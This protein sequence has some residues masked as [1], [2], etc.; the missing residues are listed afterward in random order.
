MITYLPY[1]NPEV[2]AA[3]LLDSELHLQ[4]VHTL[5]L[6][7]CLHETD[8]AAVRGWS[9]HPIVPMWKGYEVQLA[10]YGETMLFEWRNRKGGLNGMESTERRLKW[11]FDTA[12]STDDFEMSMPP[13]FHDEERISRLERNSRGVLLTLD[14][15]QTVK[16]YH[17]L[18][19]DAIPDSVPYYPRADGEE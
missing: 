19:P 10:L 16:H 1:R 3:Q 12:T 8:E 6:L 18:W 11:H 4:M 14:A 2:T 15:G 5:I 17:N 13:W 7:D 9:K